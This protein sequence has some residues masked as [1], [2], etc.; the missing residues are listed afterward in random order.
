ML[1]TAS[2]ALGD[3]SDPKFLQQII[4][5][6]EGSRCAVQRSCGLDS[7]IYAGI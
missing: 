3:Q 1:S 5:E 6:F 2:V 7:A 4:D